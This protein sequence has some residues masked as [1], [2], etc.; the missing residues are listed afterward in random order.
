MRIRLTAIAAGV[1]VLACATLRATPVAIGGSVTFPA[2]GPALV[3]PTGDLLATDTRTL[4]LT[5]TA[6]PGMTF[7]FP[8]TALTSVQLTSEVRR[9][10]A[11]GQVSFLYRLDPQSEQNFGAEGAL[12]MYTSF[13][14]FATDV[15]AEPG[16]AGVIVA[17][18]PADGASL[19]ANGGSMGAGHPPSIAV[20]TD[21][22]TFDKNGTLTLELSDEFA[23]VDASNTVATAMATFDGIFEPAAEITQPPPPPPPTG[24]PLP[25]GVWSGLGLLAC[26]GAVAKVRQLRAA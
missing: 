7:Q 26:C 19:S 18:S 3:P 6:P 8:E 25:P 17:R 13:V 2:G 9:V 11:T 24:V 1:M 10:P 20:V 16:G 23:F 21:A 22:T 5:Y 14:G 15:T 12:A 4:D